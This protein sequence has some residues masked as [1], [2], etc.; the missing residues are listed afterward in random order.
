M[1]NLSCIWTWNHSEGRSK[2]WLWFWKCSRFQYIL[3]EYQK[4]K[5]ESHL[6]SEELGYVG[7][8]WDNESLGW[9]C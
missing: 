7:L 4:F 5:D 9:S 6:E 1:L 3:E 8:V 2:S